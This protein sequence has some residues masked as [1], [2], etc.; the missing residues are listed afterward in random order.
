MHRRQART[1]LCL[2]GSEQDTGNWQYQ[3]VPHRLWRCQMFIVTM[4]TLVCGQTI[5]LQD[6]KLHLSQPA[7][8][9]SLS[10]AN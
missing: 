7:R 4:T 9:I 3:P 10:P 2:D 6:K 8:L 5:D 1:Y